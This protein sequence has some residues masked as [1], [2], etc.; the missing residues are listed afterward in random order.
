MIV[1][2]DCCDMTFPSLP[3]RH[4]L[5]RP[6]GQFEGPGIVYVRHVPE[7]ITVATFLQLRLTTVFS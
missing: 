5:S 2:C 6:E 4:V 1:P 7:R 3:T